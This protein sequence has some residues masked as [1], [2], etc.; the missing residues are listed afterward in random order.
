MKSKPSKK[1]TTKKTSSINNGAHAPEEITQDAPQGIAS[2]PGAAP[3]SPSDAGLDE[4]KKLEADIAARGTSAPKEDAPAGGGEA[5]AV[6]KKKRFK[7]PPPDNLIRI[8][9]GQW[10]RLRDWMARRQLGI[11]EEHA[12]ILIDQEKMITALVQPTIA[13]LDEYLPESWVSKIEEN[14]PALTFFLCLMEAEMSFAARITQAKKEWA[15]LKNPSS[16]AAPGDNN[17]GGFNRGGAQ[18]APKP[19]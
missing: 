11:P 14:A 10:W 2:A 1:K 16:P 19:E 7:R 18:G 4:L 5:A 3:A 8:T 15:Q 12:G 13:C 6:P 9:W 17:G